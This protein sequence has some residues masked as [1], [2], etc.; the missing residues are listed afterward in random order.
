MVKTSIPFKKGVPHV[1]CGARLLSTHKG[2]GRGAC[3][4][5]IRGQNPFPPPLTLVCLLHQVVKISRSWA[6]IDSTSSP[7]K[8]VRSFMAPNSHPKAKD[9]GSAPLWN[10]QSS[11]GTRRPRVCSQD[12]PRVFCGLCYQRKAGT[13]YSIL[14]HFYNDLIYNSI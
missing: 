10:V 13:F 6:M 12:H 7:F 8:R 4:T 2:K 5:L 14:S 11:R 9:K 1:Y 3:P